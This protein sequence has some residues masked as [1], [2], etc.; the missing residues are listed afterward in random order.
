[1]FV[2]VQD[3]FWPIFVE[4]SKFD[5]EVLSAK[6]K[7][8]GRE[9]YYVYMSLCLPHS[10]HVIH[11]QLTFSNYIQLTFKKKLIIANICRT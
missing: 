3:T 11:V 4:H 5:I 10:S 6:R 7:V 8:N 1:M 9:D 2:R